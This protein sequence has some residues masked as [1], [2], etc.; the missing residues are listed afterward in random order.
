MTIDP[1]PG[2]VN[3]NPFAH[4]FNAINLTFELSV[5]MNQ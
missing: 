4:M 5:E 3:T 2:I 1:R